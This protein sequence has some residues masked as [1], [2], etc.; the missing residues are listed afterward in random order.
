MKK[1]KKGSVKRIK[2]VKDK[3]I[4]LNILRNFDLCA[5]FP[6]FTKK[7]EGICRQLHKD[8]CPALYRVGDTDEYKNLKN[9]TDRK[10]RVSDKEKRRRKLERRSL[11]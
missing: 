6:M 11:E 1:N 5:C 3:L 8:Q 9:K 2:R 7:C 10:D 4:Q